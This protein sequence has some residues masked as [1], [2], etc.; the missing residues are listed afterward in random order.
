M[1][2]G[3]VN[4]I[5]QSANQGANSINSMMI[6]SIF[7]FVTSYTINGNMATIFDG[8]MMT[9]GKEKR[10][11]TQGKKTQFSVLL[12]KLVAFYFILNIHFDHFLLTLRICY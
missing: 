3:W 9:S 8:M 4:H 1:C 7:K 12:Q 6:V 10:K 5:F 2:L 11:R